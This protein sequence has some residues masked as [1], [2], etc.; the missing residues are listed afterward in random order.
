MNEE[1]AREALERLVLE[2][3]E[4]YGA[5]S[6][7]I[8]R[9]PAYIQ[10]FV[11]RGTPRKLDEEDRRVLAR[12]FGVAE[13]VL[14]GRDAPLVMAAVAPGR[15]GK[16][17]RAPVVGDMILVPRLELGASAG[18]GSL[19]QDERAAGAVAFDTRWLR[20]QG[21]RPGQV[22]IIRVD[23]ES[24][25]PTL[26]DHDDI[27]VDG[28]DGADRL[29]DG[30]YVLRMDGVLMVKRIAT[31]PRRGELSVLSDNPLYPAWRDIDPAL[32]E[33]VGRV[34]WTGRRVG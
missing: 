18:S 27:M 23:G 31:G 2:R 20:E 17:L 6:R 32:V 9:N 12:Y 13:S 28:G 5:L 8:G 30:I 11:K 3:R 33:I 24:M 7:M 29:R 15:S 14:G 21:V 26:G 22:S 16:P 25:A 19:D 34:I 4:N 1:S 10:Q